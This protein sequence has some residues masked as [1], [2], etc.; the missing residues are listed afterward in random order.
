MKP[1]GTSFYV[2]A[3]LHPEIPE[4]QF[5]IDTGAGI[6][7]LPESV[8]H[9]LPSSERPPLAATARSVF[10]GNEQGINIT[11]IVFMKIRLQHIEYQAAFHVSPDV[12]KG[13]L[14]NDFLERY[15]AHLQIAKR[16]VILNNRSID[17]YDSRG[18]P[19]HHKIVA[20]KTLFVP[21]GQRFVIP[22][23]IVGKNDLDTDVILIEPSRLMAQNNGILVARVVTT[24]KNHRLMIEVSNITD[25][26]Q[27]INRNTTLGVVHEVDDVRDWPQSGTTHADDKTSTANLT[28]QS[29]KTH[30]DKITV[31]AS[32]TACRSETY[33]EP[34]LTDS[35]NLT[36]YMQHV[37][38][39]EQSESQSDVSDSTIKWSCEQICNG[40]SEPP[41]YNADELP[42][43]LRKM[44][45][46][47]TANMQVALDKYCFFRLLQSYPD[48]FAKNRYD[49]G[50]TKLAK[51]HIDTGNSA[52]VKQKPRRLPQA[53]HGEIK[54]Q[55]TKLAETGIIKPSTGNYASNML[56]VRKK[57]GTWRICI[58]YRELN[59]RT[60][61]K[62]PYMIPRIDDTLDALTGAKLFCTL[63]LAQGYHQVELTESSKEKTAFLTPHMTPSLWEFDCMP[64]GITGG[65]ASFQ[66]VMDR[67]LD[68]MDHR[69]ALAYLDDIIVYGGSYREVMDR[70]ALVFERIRQAGL[71]LK[72]NK[73][74]FFEKETLYL[75]HVVSE[76][77][78]KCDPKKLE[79]VKTWPRPTTGRQCLRF[80]GFANYYN[81]FIK[82]FSELARPLYALG[83][84][85]RR[86]IKIP[87]KWTEVEENSFQALRQALLTAPVTAYP[88]TDGDWI[89]DTDASAF[90]MGAVLSQ[91]QTDENGDKQERV[92][93]YG[94]KALQGRQQRYCTRR[95]ELLA[96]V[97]FVRHFRPYLYGRFVTIRTDH[98][99]LKYLKTLN[100]PDDQFARWMQDLEETYYTIEIRK[101]KDHGNADAMS[102][103]NEPETH[104]EGKKCI[105]EGVA[106]MERTD[107]STDDYRK[108]SP[109]FD[110]PNEAAQKVSNGDSDSDSDVDEPACARVAPTAPNDTNEE[111]AGEHATAH[112]YAF[113]FTKKWTASELA[114]A[115]R[116]DP[117]LK[118]LYQVK[119]DG[120]GKP[121]ASELALQS[122]TTRAYFHDL[123]RIRL[124]ANKV[125]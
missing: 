118:L 124:E 106:E 5:I 98:A 101:G 58:D 93:A 35:G 44:F 9:C 33:D 87:F 40:L 42:E 32:G 53:H 18:V 39:E 60:L 111:S 62:D 17:I 81:R 122:D 69:I 11:G 48:I 37:F 30:A 108:H 104:C 105:C 92:I 49:L 2:Y 19:L 117:D 119:Q 75:G 102:R 67:L 107:P 78:I 38:A 52:P 91:R 28:V 55:V 46:E 74:T 16:K 100:N 110:M 23:R 59:S 103:L 12:Q 14:G 27:R 112:V 84:N 94:S 79:Q 76:E 10:V 85:K 71:K 96:V 31:D 26:T 15:D 36:G 6:S 109:A 64:F 4:I 82:N 65:P 34:E 73:C 13:I 80:A 56:L 61:N 22:T 54:E 89:L 24:H 83:Q 29:D 125:L 66:R 57:D 25:Q 99:S 88:T 90:A 115:Q 121:P 114:E 68:G 97:T 3:E 63:D 41:P 47:N 51:H 20:D 50:R 95:R 7:L 45:E 77:G 86:K 123:K 116:S 120:T 113:K 8:Y 21:P 1:F 43:H 72:P 70:L